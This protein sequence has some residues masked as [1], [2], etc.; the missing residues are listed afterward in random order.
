[1]TPLELEEAGLGDDA[2]D[3]RFWAGRARGLVLDLGCRGGRVSAFLRKREAVVISLD[4]AAAC[5]RATRRR[6]E[7]LPVVQ[8][9]IRR[10]MFRRLDTVLATSSAFQEL[11]N[12]ADRAR[13]LASVRE[14][15]RPSGSLVLALR[16]PKPREAALVPRRLAAEFVHGGT[17]IARFETVRREPGVA[18]VASDWVVAGKPA[19]TVERR[20]AVLDRPA[21]Q[22][23]LRA[24]GFSLFALFRDW[25]EAPFD[26]RGPLLIVEA[27]RD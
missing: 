6:S 17:R 9:D 4:P 20:L 13:C 24:A 5:V 10:F 1:M 21:L 7:R 22:E 2:P 8:A 16:A 25:N 26:D 14:S 3:L 11:P 27:A 19:G 18:V 23:E 15:L 12:R